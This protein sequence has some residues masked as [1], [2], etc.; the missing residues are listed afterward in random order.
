MELTRN[1]AV[2]I[3]AAFVAMPMC[4]A[5]REAKPPE[6]T[7]PAHSS[8]VPQKTSLSERERTSRFLQ[9]PLD[10]ELNRGEAPKDFQFVAHGPSYS[11]GIS[12][13][14]VALSLHRPAPDK[15]AANDPSLAA[16]VAVESSTLRL[17]LLG[18]LDS[19]VVTGLDA[20]PGRSNYF[21]GNDP[22]KWRVDIPH[23]NRV[24]VAEAYPGIDVVFY[25]NRQQLEYDFAV[26]ELA[27]LAAEPPP[28]KR[29]P[30]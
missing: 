7:S 18:A 2:L 11:L 27:R 19:S 14:G 12:S 24:K 10:F 9:M 8:S 1:T 3:V 26:A 30:K 23:F 5:Q 20:Q 6:T 4:A 15:S 13:S 25:G 29:S 21:I 16:P 22:A 28:L 17:K